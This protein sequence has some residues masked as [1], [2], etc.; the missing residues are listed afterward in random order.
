MEEK[1]QLK[2]PKK[3]HQVKK[4]LRKLVQKPHITTNFIANPEMTIQ[5]RRNK[6]KQKSPD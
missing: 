2:A 3:K 5:D 1:P 4:L 6:R